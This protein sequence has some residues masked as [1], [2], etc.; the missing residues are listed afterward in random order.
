M[1]YDGAAGAVMS[2]MLS[3]LGLPASMAS[4]KMAQ[5]HIASNKELTDNQIIE[6]QDQLVKDTQEIKNQPTQPAQPTI[7]QE[8]NIPQPTT[9]TQG[10][11]GRSTP[12]NTETVIQA[13]Y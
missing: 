1:T 9:E 3:A 2:L 13:C 12:V 6:L 10:I 11:I 5:K 4:R 8:Q 7:T